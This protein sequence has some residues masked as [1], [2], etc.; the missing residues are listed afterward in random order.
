MVSLG[1]KIILEYPNNREKNQCKPDFK[2]N[3]YIILIL[4]N[5]ES[6]GKSNSGGMNE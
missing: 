4:S 1:I 5:T 2:H 6:K 3:K